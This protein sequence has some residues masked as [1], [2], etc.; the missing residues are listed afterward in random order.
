MRLLAMAALLALQL[1]GLLLNGWQVGIVDVHGAEGSKMAL[2][3]P[4]VLSLAFL[5]EIPFAVLAL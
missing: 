5:Q 1:S 4:A 3:L 2:I